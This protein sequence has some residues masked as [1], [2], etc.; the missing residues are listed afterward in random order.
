MAS[1]TSRTVIVGAGAAGLAT[2][3]ALRAGGFEDELVLL[4]DELHDPYDR[5]PLSKQLLSGSWTDDRA[6]LRTREQL[7]SAGVA[8]R[9]G[10]RA[11]GLN[12][13]E[14]ALTLDDSAS[15]EY[16]ALV[17][18]TGMTP[19]RLPFG[20]DLRGV[21]LLRTMDDLVGLRSE[22]RPDSRVAVVGGGFLGC[23]I[24]ATCRLL[25]A[26][27]ALVEPMELPLR[28]VIGDDLG[29]LVADLHREHGVAW[30]L[31]RSVAGF[32]SVDGRVSGLRLTDGRELDADV[33]VVAIG[34]V[35]C[36]EWLDGSGVLLAE[37][38][39][40]RCDEHGRAQDGVWAVGDV[41]AWYSPRHA[42]WIRVEHRFTANQHAQ[43]VAAD[44]LARRP[45]ITTAA[46][47]AEP[48]VP[49]FWSDQYDFKLQVHGVP[50]G[51]FEVV[52]G[53]L[54]ER[55]FVGLYVDD[56]RVSAVA[57]AGMAKALRRWR[58]AVVDLTPV[59]DLPGWRSAV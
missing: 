19:R 13:A 33:V 22:L 55:R 20:H 46:A 16:D 27:V 49:Y 36:V 8:Y 42:R 37:S 4:G 1:R 28:N 25:G 5:P 12:T 56:G 54:D 34:A 18:A 29:A 39:G 58:Q 10:V 21:H 15:V 38:G 51:A 59:T 3:E 50:S 9:P 7:R 47:A 11:T 24:A 30:Y 41:A 32:L 48:M 26:S 53:S 17:I 14:Q 23:E 40:V 6:V 35:P 44:I 43:V 57:G 52:E 45:F 31:G 2:A